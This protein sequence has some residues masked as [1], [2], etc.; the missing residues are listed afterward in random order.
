MHERTAK[1]IPYRGF[2][3]YSSVVARTNFRV[4]GQEA[5]PKSLKANTLKR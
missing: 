2:C 1:W 3:A 5:T 4:V